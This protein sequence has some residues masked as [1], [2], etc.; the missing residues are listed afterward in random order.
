MQLAFNKPLH[1]HD[2]GFQL[3][4]DFPE[5][6]W[7]LV[8]YK[9]SQV[10]PWYKRVARSYRFNRWFK[11]KRKDSFSNLANF[12]YPQVILFVF[13]SWVSLPKKIIVPLKVTILRTYEPQ[14]KAHVPLLNL[15]TNSLEQVRSDLKVNLVLDYRLYRFETQLPSLTTPSFNN[16][17]YTDFL[18]FKNNANTK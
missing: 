14:V 4:W 11:R 8:Y 17:L 9:N 13:P 7:V 16:D 2:K 15:P 3:D 1:F 10:K 12:L 6:K 18:N 5:A